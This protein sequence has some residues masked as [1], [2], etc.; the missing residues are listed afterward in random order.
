MQISQKN[1]LKNI[2]TNPV[3]HVNENT[4]S[5]IKNLQIEVNQLFLFIE[6]FFL[7]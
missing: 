4:S 6:S 7:Q 1:Y 5:L 3:F 2:C